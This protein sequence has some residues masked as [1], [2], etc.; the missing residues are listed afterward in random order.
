[1]A[2]GQVIERQRGRHVAVGQTVRLS[3]HVNY[4]P[5]GTVIPT[6]KTINIP[7][8][9]GTLAVH[10]EIVKSIDPVLGS[11]SKCEGYSGLGK[12]VYY[13]RTSSGLDK[14]QYT[15]SSLNGQ[16]QMDLTI[17]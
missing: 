13:T 11:G 10:D 3:G 17:D 4:R 16:V 12:G 14:F 2:S 7:P 8:S 6:A 1:V 9:H 15:S 5:C